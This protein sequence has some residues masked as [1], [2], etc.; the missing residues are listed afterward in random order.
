MTFRP[1]EVLK[2][3]ASI[4]PGD[5]VFLKLAHVHAVFATLDF[6]DKHVY[7]AVHSVDVKVEV[8]GARSVTACLPKEP[9]GERVTQHALVYIGAV[10][11]P[12]VA[13]REPEQAH[14]RAFAFFIANLDAV[15]GLGEHGRR[16]ATDLDADVVEGSL[17]AVGDIVCCPVQHP[18]GGGNLF[19]D[20]VV[21]TFLL[22]INENDGQVVSLSI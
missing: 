9:I 10:Q 12:V 14:V 3:S 20:F 2:P 19:G 18:H 16:L 22:G 6:F 21:K 13:G 5:V 1:S 4:P 15:A 7:A 17:G 8:L 11:H